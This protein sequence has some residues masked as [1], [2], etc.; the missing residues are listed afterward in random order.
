MKRELARWPALA[1]GLPEAFEI[2][3]RRAVRGKVHRA[4]SDYRWIAASPGLDPAGRRWEEQVSFGVEDEPREMFAWRAIDGGYAAVHAYPSRAVDAVGRPGGLEK[5]VLWCAADPSVP[6]AAA[7]FA[8]LGEAARSTD[9]LWWEAHTLPQWTDGQFVLPVDEAACPPCR[10]TAADLAT[11]VER[12]LS[13]LR[14]AAASD[15]LES[16]YAQWLEDARPAVLGGAAQPLTPLAVAALLLPLTQAQAANFSIAGGVPS[17]QF[18]ADRL[19][20]W[21]AVACDAPVA[22]TPAGSGRASEIACALQGQA[23]PPAAALDG[24][25]ARHLAAFLRSDRRTIYGR[26]FPH[27]SWHPIAEMDGSALIAK[28]REFDAS[29]DA[30]RQEPHGPAHEEARREHLRAKADEARAWLYVFAPGPETIRTLPPREGS[31]VPA[32]WFARLLAAED[33]GALD[34]YSTVEMAALIRHSLDPPRQQPEVVRWIEE[35]LDA[36]IEVERHDEILRLIE[37]PASG[38]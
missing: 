19:S 16:M 18:R 26:A 29:I 33:L 3:Y 13:E 1:S 35:Y 36:M 25:T 37:Q 2:R 9:A 12:G 11:L 17:S 15:A 7:A 24:T 32:L 21:S 27:G 10:L 14:A 34:R 20:T 23:P 6:A 38:T 30:A 28:V 4:A 31:R 22:P 5:H 8:L